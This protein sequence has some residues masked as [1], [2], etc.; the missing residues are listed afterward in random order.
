MPA[1]PRVAPGVS[2]KISYGLLCRVY[3]ARKGQHSV[4]L[5][6]VPA[7]CSDSP[8]RNLTS[9]AAAIVTCRLGS[10]RLHRCPVL[11]LDEA[12]QLLGDIYTADMRHITEHCGKR[13]KPDPSSSSSVDNDRSSSGT[14]GQ[15]TLVPTQMQTILVSA[16]LWDGVLS[17]FNSWCPGPTFITTGGAPTWVEDI[18]DS[19]QGLVSDTGSTNPKTWGWGVKG[20]EGPASVVQQ[21]PKT[22]GTVG[23]AEGS[24][25][26]PT[27]PP[28]LE[29]M[30]LVV[31]PQHK[32]DAVRRAMYALNVGMGLGFMN[33][34]QRLKDVAAKV[35]AKKIEVGEVTGSLFLCLH[36]V[37]VNQGVS[38]YRPQAL[39]DMSLQAC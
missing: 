25:L 36:Q 4:I 27:L 34:Q 15:Q 31:N 2:F 35:A 14:Q 23:G 22:Q 13:L 7:A 18:A 32:A 9:P 24:G 39:L 30:F 28:N 17:R 38:K 11:I 10:L 20:W 1:A 5:S 6:S 16:T 26:V 33:W 29:H 3:L 37:Y 8:V 21:G 12:D 19:A